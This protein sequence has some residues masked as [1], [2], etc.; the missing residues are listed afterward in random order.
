MNKSQ[1]AKEIRNMSDAEVESQRSR[2]YH[3][4]DGESFGSD[5]EARA[6]A[7]QRYEILNDELKRRRENRE[8]SGKS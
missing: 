7:I 8:A 3:L 1:Y 6:Q 2:A 5:H 4:K